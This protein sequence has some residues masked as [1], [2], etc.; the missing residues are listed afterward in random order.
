[1]FNT[2]FIKKFLDP[3]HGV[4]GPREKVDVFVSKIQRVTSSTIEEN[5]QQKI[6]FWRALMFLKI[7]SCTPKKRGSRKRNLESFTFSTAGSI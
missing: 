7:A 5:T 1:M 2:T 4:A 3:A 6:H